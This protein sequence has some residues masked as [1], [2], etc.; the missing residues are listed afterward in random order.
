[1]SVAQAP[2]TANRYIVP[3]LA[4]ERCAHSGAQSLIFDHAGRVVA[5]EGLSASSPWVVKPSTKFPGKKS[6]KG[7]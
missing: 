4:S 6:K 1:M 5:T 2:T 7:P 3:A